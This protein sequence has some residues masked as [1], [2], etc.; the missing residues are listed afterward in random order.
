MKAAM[1]RSTAENAVSCASARTAVEGVHSLSLSRIQLAPAPSPAPPS[2]GGEGHE[3][4]AEGV[5]TV[6]EEPQ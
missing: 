1:S 2:S 5:P 6:P 4:T 3:P